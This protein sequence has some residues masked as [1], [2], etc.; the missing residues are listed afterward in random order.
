MVY[1]EQAGTAP[2]FGRWRSSGPSRA[3]KI[4]STV[5]NRTF[6]ESDDRQHGALR[7]HP[8]GD[9]F[10][11][12]PGSPASRESLKPLADARINPA[13]TPTPEPPTETTPRTTQA[14]EPQPLLMK[15]YRNLIARGLL[16]ATLCPLA[17]HAAVNTWNNATGN[18]MWDTTS[19]NWTSPQL[20]AQGDDAIFS[21]TG[22]GTV[23]LLEAITAGNLT[24]NAD[25]YTITGSGSP[26]ILSNDTPTITVYSSAAIAAVIQGTN[27]LTIA[28]TTNLTLLGDTGFG[29]ANQYTGGTYVRGGTLIL[30]AAG[31]NTGGASYA[32]DRLE[33]ID[34]GATVRIGTENDGVNNV[35]PAD[36]QLL[37]GNNQGRMNLTGGTFDN[38]GD[39]N[40]LNYPCP[41]GF[42]TILNSSPWKR[43]VMKLQGGNTGKTY[44]FMGSINDGGPNVTTSQGIA[45]QENIDMNG[46]GPYTLELGGSNSFTGFIRLNNGGNGNKIVLLPGGTLGY[47]APINCPA[48]Q[49]LMNSGTIDLNGTSQK[50]GYVYT[51][52]NADSIITN[53]AL[54]TIS[55]LTVCYNCTN[56]VPNNGAATPRG[57]RTGLLDD[58]TTGGTLALVK[59]GIAL[60][61][62]GVYAADVGN[63]QPCNYHG[64]TTVNNGILEVLSTSGISPNSAYRLNTPGVLQLDYAGAVTIRQFYVNGIRMPAGTYGSNNVAAITGPGQ[65]VIL[66]PNLWTDSP[67][68][69]MQ[70]DLLSANWTA[71]AVWSQGN[72]AIFG[73][74]G[75]GTVD[76]MTPI[77]AHNLTFNADGYTIQGAGSPLTLIDSNATLTANKS[78]TIAATILGTNG[79]TI[80]GPSNVT[81]LGDTSFGVANQ[82]SGGTYIRSG[83]VILQCA[84]ASS[85]GVS[86]A[87]DSIEALDA[88]ATV[89]MGTTFN[90]TSWGSQRDQIAATKAG[91]HLHLTGGTLD[92][93]NDPKNQRIPVP[94]GT[95]LIINSGSAVQA[96]L[97]IITDGQ[98]HTFSGVIADG[99]NGNLV[100]GNLSQGPGYQIGIV[101]VSGGVTAAQQ[102]T[103][104]GAH[105]Y[106][107]STRLDNGVSIK[108]VGA[109]T[110]G[111]PTTNGLTGPLRLYNASID[112]NGTS[113]TIALM[114]GGST[115]GTIYN[116]AAGTVS[117]LTIGYGNEQ[118]NRSAPFQLKDNLG[119]GGIFA[120][121]KI[122]T[123]P[124]QTPVGGPYTGVATNCAQTLAGVCTYS[125]DTTIA[126]GTLILS[127]ASAVSPN[128][129][130]RVFTANYGMLTLTNFTTANVRQLW[131]NGVQKPNG[132]Y[133]SIGNTLGAIPVAGI[134]PA[135]TGT[136]TVTGYAPVSLN[137]AK[138][139]HSLNFS[140]AGVYKL[141][142][143]T[144]VVGGTWTDV[145]GGYPSPVSVPVD[146]AKKALFFRLASF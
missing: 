137:V 70:W 66:P 89:K 3:D 134:D 144:N 72:D 135:S 136:L 85:S 62:I 99:N 140:W 105:T 4:H 61:P 8:V 38:N 55:T 6:R 119:T 81:F 14:T 112:L 94:E 115:S 51:G 45:Y 92:L 15:P 82:Y 93:F 27:G 79:L 69:N 96:G 133:G 35:R 84:N 57:I 13:H 143:T 43:A 141:Q 132:T 124:Y 87:I 30:K 11:A 86:Y 101:Q 111:R 76:I 130:Y 24:F 49:I 41:E 104:S 53:S 52:N 39:D 12:G 88:G 34:T 145:A 75:V 142:S 22:A 17:A 108:L 98:N 31:V 56:L 59:E 63:A 73:A 40:G 118:A 100:G 9:L 138:G 58:P 127:G 126:G 122:I 123:A 80:Q 121:K 25:G 48:R 64:D 37:R 7:L 44:T 33:A 125:G 50:V 46:G 16:L 23:S 110:L 2:S 74:L 131:I 109:A 5:M 20:W 21:A 102:W 128:S 60:Q 146:H 26:L 10:S 120:L 42:G 68:G 97:Q 106:S 18:A 91:T 129:A 116:S 113:Q 36:G 83:T 114:Q 28:G 65:L 67:G 139:A 90:G 1:W 117:T 19:T 47:P 29:S 71:P 32:V 95:G 77:E 103:W 107:G 78:V 54:G